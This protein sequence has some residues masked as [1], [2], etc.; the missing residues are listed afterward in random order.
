MAEHVRFCG[1]NKRLVPA[2]GTE[3]EVGTLH[4]HANEREA[5]SCWR[6][7]P[8]ELAIVNRTG[9]VWLSVMGRT[10]PPVF[11]SGV[12]LMEAHDQDTGEPTTYHSSGK[13]VVDDASFFAK[14]HHGDQ[15]YSDMTHGYHL[16]QVVAELTEIG[17][18]WPFLATGYLH[19]TE[20]DCWQ[21]EP[22]EARR[23]RIRD[24]FGELIETMVWCVTGQMYIDGVKQN[25]KA[26]NAEQYAKIAGFP[27]S[28]V[29]KVADRIANLKATLRDS[30]REFARMY[31]GEHEEFLAKVVV[32]APDVLKERYLQ[33]IEQ[34]KQLL[35]TN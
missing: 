2:P 31:L 14:L 28:A 17:A 35:T 19:D 4:V 12:P 32:H 27:P 9:E 25:R 1:F 20:E 24:R 11:V 33:T 13:H 30:S 7:S 6:L 3:H 26:R 21:D 8:E 22:I 10:T 34:I 5:I 15:V 29:V 16:D 18:E 23:A